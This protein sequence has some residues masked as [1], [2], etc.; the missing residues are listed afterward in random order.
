MNLLRST[1]ILLVANSADGFNVAPAAGI[2]KVMKGRSSDILPAMAQTQSMMS[3]RG[4]QTKSSLMATTSPSPS[5]TELD[6]SAILK[7][8]VAAV[9]QLSLISGFFYG[10]DYAL[11]ATGNSVLPTPVTWIMCYAFSL[12]SR[13]FNPLNNERPNRQKAVEGEKSNGF[14]DRVQPS[15][16]PPGVVFPIMWL[17]IIGPLRATSST[18]IIESLGGYFSLPLMSLM[19]HLTCG[20][21]WNTINNTE[22]RFGTSVLGISTVYFSALHAAYRYYEVDPLAGKLLGATAIWLTI[23]SALII[24]TWRL[25]PDQNGERGSLLPRKAVGEESVTTFSWGKKS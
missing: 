2:S 22:K 25:N 1:L 24:D 8:G 19:L 6:T 11:T 12:K 7:Y 13:T 3:K 14:K 9:T 4:S 21:I 16:T 15:W 10:V 17:L 23:A 20:D 5:D 18:M